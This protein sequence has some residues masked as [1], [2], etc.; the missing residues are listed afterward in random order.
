M[1]PSRGISDCLDNRARFGSHN[2]VQYAEMLAHEIVSDKIA[3]ALVECRRALQIGKQESEA[4]NLESLI[5]IKCVGV[6]EIA[7]RLVGQEPLPILARTA[8]QAMR[9]WL[10]L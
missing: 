10:T 1:L 8:R 7:K 6:I 2:F 5:R 9:D 4:C 3:Y